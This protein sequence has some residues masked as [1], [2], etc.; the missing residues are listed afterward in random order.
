MAVSAG[1]FE[2][3]EIEF[4]D[5]LFLLN[6]PINSAERCMLSDALP[7]FPHQ[8]IKFFLINA[9]QIKSVA[10]IIFFS[11]FNNVLSK[12]FMFLNL[13]LFIFSMFKN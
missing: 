1:E 12:Y 10:K 13:I 4:K 11:S 6:L 9:R 5:F 8:S 3:N 7:P 2:D